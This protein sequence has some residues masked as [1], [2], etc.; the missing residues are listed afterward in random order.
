MKPR[1]RFILGP[2]RGL[3]REEAARYVGIGITKFDEMV[4][5]REMP[6]PFK[7]GSRVLWDIHRLD[8]AID[9]LVE[10]ASGNPWDAVA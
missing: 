4:A 9:Q 7:I 8:D 6:R 1:D 3:S 2:R 10:V 5:S